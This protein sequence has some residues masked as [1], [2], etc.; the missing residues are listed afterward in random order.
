MRSNSFCDDW[1]R[2]MSRRYTRNRLCLF[3]GF[4]RTGRVASH[5]LDYLEE[6]ARHSTV[7]YLAD[8]RLRRRELRKVR[9]ICAGAWVMDHGKY[10]FGSYSELAG[11]LLGW[12]R[13]EHFDEVIFAND[14]CFCLQPFDTVFA[15]MDQEDC[16]FWCLLGTDES[17]TERL[18]TFREY[19]AMPNR[20][21]P[22]LCFGSYFMAFRPGV[23]RDT[24]FRRFFDSVERQPDRTAVCQRYEM[25]LTAFLKEKGFRLSAFVKTV[26]KRVAIYDEQAFRLLKR[27]FPLLKKRIFTVNPLGLR[28]LEDWPQVV[29][30]YVGNRRIYSYLD[31]I[32][33]E[34]RRPSRISSIRKRAAAALDRWVPPIVR[35]GPR[36]AVKLF[37]PPILLDTYR[38]VRR[39]AG[40][41]R[42]GGEILRTLPLAADRALAKAAGSDFLVVFFNLA[43]DT[44]GGGMLSI[45]RFASAS[46]NLRQELGFEVLVSGVP[47]NEPV[48]EY[49]M[50]EAAAPMVPFPDITARLRPAR[51]I[52]N[53]PEYAVPIFL[54][55]LTP[56]EVRWLKSRPHLRLN[57]MD[58]NHDQLPGPVFIERLRDLSD[59][60]TITT[61]HGRYTTPRTA[62][63]TGCPVSLLTPFLPQL[64][65]VPFAAKEKT[66]VVSPDPGPPTSDG[67]GKAAILGAL[68]AELPDYRIVTV[69]NMPLD[70]YKGLIAR[71]RFALT[72]GEGWDGYFVEP[73]LSGSISFAVYND[74][75]FPEEIRDSPTVYPSWESLRA[76]IAADI[77]RLEAD[78]EQYASV[79]ESTERLIRKY[80]NDE[81][82]SANLRDFYGRKF[83][84][85]PDV[86]S[87]D[88]LYAGAGAAAPSVD[89]RCADGNR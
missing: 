9:A 76:R 73:I 56:E 15:G 86:L 67:G 17:N 20:K 23:I 25:G 10:D 62:S 31:E 49:S 4:N 11:N 27:G 81:L 61:A 37:A 33:F 43:Y 46:L 7:Y 13:L 74:R 84:Y 50:F 35:N 77:R 45:N 79:Q 82:S 21:V 66:L 65:R 6:L 71:A 32:G 69:E 78:P 2:E 83:A 47:L 14:S 12:D 88:P 55:Q 89:L 58:Q 80:A 16:D 87:W 68:A 57:I 28:Y 75:F 5:V 64:E 53:L 54:E 52:V 39:A 51:L 59:D 3:A 41:R 1:N 19:A 72:F 40:R 26:Y 63:E 44:I 22:F 34:P 38:G 70:S 36:A 29:S 24:D 30:S 85:V 60:V 18:Y 8:G 48:V 42:Q